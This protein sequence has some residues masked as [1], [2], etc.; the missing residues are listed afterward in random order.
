MEPGGPPL[1]GC[2]GVLAAS[3]SRADSPRATHQSVSIR[4]ACR[5]RSQKRRRYGPEPSGQTPNPDCR[6]GAGPFSNA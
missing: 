5:R 3:T 6:R 2:T 1:I 4:L